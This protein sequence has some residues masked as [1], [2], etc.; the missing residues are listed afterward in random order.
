MHLRKLFH[1]QPR[2]L[3]FT[4]S[5][6]G[7]NGFE[8]GMRVAAKKKRQTLSGLPRADGNGL[9][10]GEYKHESYLVDGVGPDR[11]WACG[12]VLRSG[13]CF[14]RRCGGNRNRSAVLGRGRSGRRPI[15]RVVNPVSRSR[16]FDGDRLCS[17]IGTWRGC[18]RW[19]RRLG[20]FDRHGH[21][22]RSAGDKVSVPRVDGFDGIGSDRKTVG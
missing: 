22:C 12:I 13:N 21:R 17:G 15:Q 8:G 11:H 18:K 16:V 14:D 5:S 10:R 6:C 4:N 1:E 19:R 9:Q 3:A 7:R 20:R 2:F